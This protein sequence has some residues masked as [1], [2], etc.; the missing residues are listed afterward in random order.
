MQIFGNVDY[1]LCTIPVSSRRGK[2]VIL[3]DNDACIKAWIKGLSPAMR[4]VGRTYRM[5]LDWLWERIRTDPRVFIKYVG[6]KVQIA[7]LFTKGSFSAELWY[8]FC[9]FAQIGIA[10]SMSKHK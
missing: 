5:D 1:V 4:H 8:R 10:E 6:T 3:E 7:D 9:R 2:R